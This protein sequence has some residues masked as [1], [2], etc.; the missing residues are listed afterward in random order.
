MS[1]ILLKRVKVENEAFVPSTDYNYNYNYYQSEVALADHIHA[2][3][4]FG[5]VTSFHQ[6]FS[7]V[8]R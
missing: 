7:D 4:G 1:Q 6:N 2:T 5:N 8:I 3:Q